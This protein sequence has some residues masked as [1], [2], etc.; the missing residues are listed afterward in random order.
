MDNYEDKLFYEN[1]M[2]SSGTKD[3]EIQKSIHHIKSQTFY[4]K[5]TVQASAKYSFD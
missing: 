4:L 3:L 1:C 2:L 5:A